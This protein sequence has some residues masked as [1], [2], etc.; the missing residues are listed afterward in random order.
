MPAT[1]DGNLTTHDR[2]L[3]VVTTTHGRLRGDH[4]RG[5]YRFKGIPFAAPPVGD[6]R[7]APPE[8]PTSWADV[9]IA[10]GDFPIAPQP[11]DMMTQL[12]G[13]DQ[14]PTYSEAD[15]LTL[16]VWTPTPD[17]ARRP[18]MVW[19]HGGAFVTG[20]GGI[21]WYDGAN[22]TKRDV[23]VV[24]VN[25]RL[26][27]LGFLHLGDL[28]GEAFAGSGNVGLLD[29]AAALAWV[30][31][32]IE[33]FGG[34]PGNVTI[35]GESAGGMSVGTHLALPAS[36][37]LFHRAIAQSG[38]VSNVS[39]SDRATKV[40]LALLDELGLDRREVEQLRTIDVA[41][42]LE[43]QQRVS[44][45]FGIAGGLPFQ[46][47]WDQTVLPRRPLDAIRD[48]SASGCDLLIG[49]NRDEMRVFAAM[50]PRVAPDDDD[51]LVRRGTTLVGDGAAELIAAYRRTRPE[52]TARELFEVIGTDA[53]FRIPALELAAAQ[54]RHAP[55]R[56]YEFH[57]ESTGLGGILGATHAVDVPFVFDNLDAPG[58]AVFTGE[59]DEAV[60]TFAK[61][62]AD[63]WCHFARTGN[64]DGSGLP[65]WPRWEDPDYST[66]ILDTDARVVA[67]PA[68][69]ER[70]AWRAS[71]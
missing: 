5:A 67:D 58:A 63:A 11:P 18:V 61:D 57:Q 32:N 4:T 15:C 60:R 70:D 2:D 3:E 65:S 52:A 23:V 24:T 21:P 37:G 19:I 69:D 36:A 20:S 54:Q 51:T 29:Q 39:D 59:P 41:S 35:F 7:F 27:A 68:A 17:G 64:P 40:A 45:E 47:V 38:A 10:S 25:Y 50:D 9:R 49:T 16:N 6:L 30:R 1:D 55:C 13:A 8:P 48:G 22:L 44:A 33:A 62:L 56:V 71:A 14:G 42:L 31:D 28:G 34:D 26:G 53:V 12:V 66:M 43:A 46:P